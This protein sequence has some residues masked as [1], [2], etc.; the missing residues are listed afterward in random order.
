MTMH[1]KR[2]ADEIL[3]ASAAKLNGYELKLRRVLEKNP[4]MTV[5]QGH[6]ILELRNYEV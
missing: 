2:T 4:G 1:T 6:R 3:R 5:S